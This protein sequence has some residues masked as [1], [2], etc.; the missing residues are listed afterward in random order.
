MR[1]ISGRLGFIDSKAERGGSIQRLYSAPAQ[2]TEQGPGR[3]LRCC[4]RPCSRGL[5][6]CGRAQWLPTA[7]GR[8]S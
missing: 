2:Q 5:R 8:G 4:C 3:C 7:R 1:G 6:P